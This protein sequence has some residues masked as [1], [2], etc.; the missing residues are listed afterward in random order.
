VVGIWILRFSIPHR[1]NHTRSTDLELHCLIRTQIRSPIR[2]H[3]L[4]RNG[5]GMPLTIEW[6]RYRGSWYI[7]DFRHSDRDETAAAK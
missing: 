6:I 1:R 5:D 7:D 2:I 4:D 3:C